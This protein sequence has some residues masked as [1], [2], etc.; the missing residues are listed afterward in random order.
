MII[1]SNGVRIFINESMHK[2]IYVG[3]S[4]FGFENDIKDNMIGIAHLLEHILISFDPSKFI[5]NAYTSRSYMSFWCKSINNTPKNDAI[6]TLISWFFINGKLKNEFSIS[7][8]RDHIKELE[9][10]YYFRNELFHCADV[11]T[12]LNGGDLYNGGRITMMKDINKLNIFLSQRMDKIVGP[13]VII[14]VNK[15][16]KYI[17][18][19]LK[20]T[21][22]SLP[23][24]PNVLYS[25][26]FNINNGKV[27]M[28]PSPF[29]TIMIKIKPTLYNVLS[30]MCLYE[31]YHLIDYETIGN[32]LYITISFINESDYDNFLRGTKNIKFIAP[33]QVYLN[34]NDDFLMNIYLCFPWI[35]NDIF[36]YITFLNNECQN[37][38]DS[39]EAEIKESI[40]NG[41]IIAIYPNF[42]Q[43]MFNIKDNQFHKL[44][45][46]DLHLHTHNKN[47]IKGYNNTTNILLMRKQSINK[48]F[49]KYSDTT[50]I[51]YAN[52]IIKYKNDISFN[53]TP[54]GIIIKHH[55]SYDDIKSI[56]DSDTFIKYSKLKP[57]VTYQYILLSFFASGNSIDDI[58]SNKEPTLFF[59]NEYNNKIVFSKRVK[60]DITTK[61]TFVCGIIK[62]HKLSNQLITD[63]M[64]HFKKK[65][66]IYSLDFTKLY[67]KNTFYIFMFTIYPDKVYK[68]LT[69]N[70]YI[71]NYC[72]A[73]SKQG[74]IE[75][76]SN[77]KKDIVVNL[78]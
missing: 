77:L 39:L 56:F 27:V 66:L 29:Y 60:Y 3:I 54:S 52:L 35:N 46:I 20:E 34:H 45:V 38:L 58:I 26:Q 74:N 47:I 51:N 24:L 75:D 61:S 73:V 28:L 18:S 14:F 40:S 12:F 5:A 68:Y 49:V 62:G 23:I 16:D 50:L 71:S 42:S 11:L 69:I 22:G 76:F 72:L 53:K 9:N 4:N 37:I 13:N 2:D 36:N 41:D 32:V 19:L 67:G 78:L 64:W 65:G 57:A 33:T 63:I 70:P 21:F 7:K 43:S 31:T 25:S 30:I 6:K 15:L 10:E 17:L 55:F 48:I 8:I 59:S 44:I 1:L